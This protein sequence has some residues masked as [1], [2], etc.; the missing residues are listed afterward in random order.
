VGCA[1]SQRDAGF[2]SGLGARLAELSGSAG[3][4]AV[5][6]GA[7]RWK[8]ILSGTATATATATVTGLSTARRKC[9]VART[10]PSA[11]RAPTW[12]QAGSVSI[13]A[14]VDGS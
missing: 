6:P 7:R 5:Q 10:A 14:K 2:I 13:C 4:R 3:E 11:G 1:S 8:L 12:L 9:A